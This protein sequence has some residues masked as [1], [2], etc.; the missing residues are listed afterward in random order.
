MKKQPTR[1]VLLATTL[2][3]P[4]L[5]VVCAH[6]TLRENQGLRQGDELPKARLRTAEGF[7]VDT[8]SWRGTMTLLVLF[9]PVC[10]ACEAEIRT[11]NTIAPQ[12]PDLKIVLLSL[13][14]AVAQADIPFP[15]LIDPSRALVKKARRLAVPALYWIGHDGKVQYARTG[16]RPPAEEALLF[17]KLQAKGD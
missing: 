10:K 16:Q 2:T 8:D 7:P 17:R 11:L 9:N 3:L 15:V 13:D 6:R 4:V 12:F 5:L 14:P 1:W